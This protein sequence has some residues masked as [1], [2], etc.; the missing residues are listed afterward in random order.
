[1]KLDN[2]NRWL[3]LIS[4]LGVLAGIALLVSELNQ[5]TQLAET[6]AFVARMESVGN[7]FAQLALSSDLAEIVEKLDRQGLD[8]LTATERIRMR[9]W[10]TARLTRTLGPYHEYEQG[11]LDQETI[12][13]AIRLGA[14][15][16]AQLWRDLGLDFENEGF[17]LAVERMEAE[18]ANE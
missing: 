18:L 4:N 15:P 10:E 11:Y 14:A 7:S 8:S 16:R 17:R 12:N 13:N 5:A 9:G 3:T 6:E 2:V 1:M